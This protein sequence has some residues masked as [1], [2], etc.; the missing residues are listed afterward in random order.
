MATYEFVKEL[1]F[2]GSLTSWESHAIT[3]LTSATFATIAS[4]FMRQWDTTVNEQLKLAALVY[5]NSIEAMT[6]T[7]ADNHIIA[8]NSSFTKM[9]GYTA[10]EVL[11]KNPRILSSGLQSAEFYQAMWHAL[12]TTGHWQGEIQNKRKNGEKYV[13]WLSINSIYNED[14]SLHRR[15][16]LFSDITEKKKIENLVWTQA[17]YDHL[18]QL[19][20]RRLFTDRLD[21]EIR[22]A[23]RDNYL[24]ALLFIDLDRFKEVNDTQGHDVGDLLL[25]EATHRLKQCVRDSDTL[26][27]LGGDEFTV[28][29]PKVHNVTDISRIAQNIINNLSLPFMLKGKES[30]I[31]AS[32][33]IALFPNDAHAM[34]DLIKHAD[35]AMYAA[36]N[37]GRGCFRFFTKAMQDKA[38]LRMR[39][40]SD[41]HHALDAEQFEVHYQPIVD[42]NTGCTHKAEALLRW[43]HPEYG[44]ISPSIFIPIA[45]ETGTIHDI[46]DWVFMQAAHQVKC[47]QSVRGW[48][49]QISINK[50]PVQFLGDNRGHNHWIERLREME[51]PGNR[52]TVEITESLLMSATPDITD[53]LLSF[54]DA[55]IQ[56]ALDDF[57]T[58]YSSL[59]Y[60]KKFHIDYIKIDQ[61]FTRN[62]ALDAPDL[63]LCEAIVAMGHKLGLMIIAEGVET[64][65]QFDLLQQIGCDYGQGF[66]FSRPVP[67]DQFETMM[68]NAA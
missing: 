55:G 9:T 11:G 8:I 58:G 20:N 49:L 7:D 54:R 35:Q 21:H 41:L 10:Q 6:V 17:N 24:I 62:L 38:Q 42:L 44:F 39:L 15:V 33:G 19:P 1:I 56:V 50:S 28:I 51:L 53:K 57:G 43:K 59:A 22:K 31:S 12:N 4:F 36:K 34:S 52:I 40:A 26:A 5:Q 32:M 37:D 66:L 25:I 14:G 23:K 48:D 29:I 47:W 18:T 13:E 61:S 65:S 67:A 45:E 63:A 3:I 16:A 27:R 60:L 68:E 46:G 64:Q 2:K 30:F